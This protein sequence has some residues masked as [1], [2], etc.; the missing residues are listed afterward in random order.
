M[1]NNTWKVGSLWKE[2]III[3]VRYYS[4]GT[5]KNYG[6][7]ARILVLPAQTRKGTDP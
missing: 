1:R 4:G 5:E 6:N 3:Y 2:I 7:S